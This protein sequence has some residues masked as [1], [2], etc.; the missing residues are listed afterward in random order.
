MQTLA[1]A[2]ALSGG[3]V[4]LSDNLD[5]LSPERLDLVSSVLP[6]IP[7]S[8]AV[9]DLLREPMP[10]TM[11]VE[12]KRPFESWLVIGRFNWHGRPRD[13]AVPLP[14]GRWHI[15]D[16][17]EQRYLGLH[18]AA[19]QLARVAPHGV[20]LLS[21]RAALDRPQVVGS[22][23]HYSMGA[24]EIDNVRWDGHR[25]ALRVQLRPVA[26]QA[27]E[28]LV[29]VPR[30]YRLLQATLDRAEIDVRREGQLLIARLPVDE[31]TSLTMTFS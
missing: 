19:V 31:P 26:K 2:I 24:L 30:G 11:T 25:R 21:L 28:L 3:A 29:H 1:T 27:G 9:N 7:E 16:F 22:T 14:P 20:R 23:F 10:S 8:A 6:P 18:E 4:F 13:L 15:F 17:W 5:Q 12:I